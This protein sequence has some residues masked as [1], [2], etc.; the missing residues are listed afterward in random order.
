MVPGTG[1]LAKAAMQGNHLTEGLTKAL[2]R[3]SLS[4]KANIRL[5][6]SADFNDDSNG[7]KTTF[8]ITLMAW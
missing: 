7:S 3:F 6:L 8:Q 2:L 4:L 5:L 1:C